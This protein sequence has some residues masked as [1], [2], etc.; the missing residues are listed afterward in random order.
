[1]TTTRFQLKPMEHIGAPETKQGF[2]LKLFAEVAPKYDFITKGL[3]FG[4][5]ASWKRALLAGLP[6]KARPTCVDLA[7]GTGDITR[8]LATRYPHAQITGLDLTP[9]MLEI[10]WSRTSDPRIAYVEGSMASLPFHDASIDVV[11]GGYALR[12]APDLNQAIDEISRI[13]RSGGTAAF[14][15]FSKP[16]NLLGQ[17]LNYLLLKFW[18]GLWG[19][20]LHRN[21]DVYGYIADSLKL[22]PDRHTLRSRFE[23]RGF[24]HLRSRR[25]FCG[26]LELVWF[27]KTED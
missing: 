3:S 24:R 18:G 11:T 25:L 8:L 16:K 7:C 6:A 27:Q 21:A 13:L 19:L 15:D 4:R 5:D 26:L 20:L 12:N 9:A 14:L 10:A 17:K 23:E 2:N 1:M 22:Y